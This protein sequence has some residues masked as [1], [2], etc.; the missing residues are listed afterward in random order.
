MVQRLVSSKKPLLEKLLVKPLPP[1]VESRDLIDL[2]QE[3]LL[4]ERSED[5]KRPPIFSLENFLSK[6][7]S[8]KSLMNST[9]NLDSKAH[10]SLL[11]KKPPKPI[12]SDFLKTPIFVPFM[13]K[14]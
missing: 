1:K 9:V 6:D 3:Q 8:E 14:E 2:D 5:I 12:L 11:S 13:L 4:L 7:L 10:Q